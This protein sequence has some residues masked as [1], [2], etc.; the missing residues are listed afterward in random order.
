VQKDLQHAQ[1]WHLIREK[2]RIE[3]DYNDPEEVFLFVTAKWRVS[4]GNEFSL[5]PT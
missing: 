3:V 1:E 4:A 2:Q 5:H